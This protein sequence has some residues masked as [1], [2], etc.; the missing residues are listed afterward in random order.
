MGN[1]IA[2]DAAGEHLLARGHLG[3]DVYALESGERVE[4]KRP[5]VSPT[6]LKLG[7]EGTLVMGC[8]EKGIWLLEGGGRPRSVGFHH[9]D[10]LALDWSPTGILVSAGEDGDLR[11][12]DGY[13]LAH[14]HRL[15]G[16]G[17][18]VKAHAFSPGGSLVAS[19]S[20]DGTLRIWDAATGTAASVIEAHPRGVSA[21]AWT[22]DGRRIVSGGEQGAL[23]LWD[24][25][26]G[27]AIQSVQAHDGGIQD[28]AVS[29]DGSGIAAASRDGWLSLWGSDR[30]E[31]IA[32]VEA[33]SGGVWAVAYHPED[34]WLASAGQ[35]G[36][37]R[38]WRSER[39]EREETLFPGPRHGNADEDRPAMALRWSPDGSR[40]AAGWAN[41]DVGV[42]ILG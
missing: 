5:P 15:A 22:P 39:L 4:N 11:L 40:I 2:W 6:V 20:D 21:L 1:V 10:I 24:P 35:D 37:V 23:S 16:H 25:M 36:K 9:R 30:L 31:P 26:E 33:H 14:R 29:P 42:R 17:V 38:L 7:S 28:L 3:V 32:S 18:R 13:D 12:W 41:S 34:K 19:G 8:P 27:M